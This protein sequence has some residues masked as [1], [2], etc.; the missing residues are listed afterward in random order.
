MSHV[1]VHGGFSTVVANANPNRIL[2][3][4]VAREL[5]AEGTIGRLYAEYFVT[6]GNGTS[7]ANGARYGVEWAAELRK[8]GVQ[9]AILTST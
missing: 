7:V 6:T 9:A 8:Q 4:D 3:L 1:S 2:P 5:Q